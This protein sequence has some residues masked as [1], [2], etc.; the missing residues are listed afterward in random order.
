MATLG[1]GLLP[2]RSFTVSKDPAMLLP[3]LIV[4]GVLMVR[5]TTGR[6]VRPMCAFQSMT[7]SR[8]GSKTWARRPR[9]CPRDFT[10]PV[11]WDKPQ[12]LVLPMTP[13][14]RYLHPK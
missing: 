6:R 4:A 5:S 10:M 1:G 12:K 2:A 13:L 14:S 11:G 3:V 8:G 9:G 7:E